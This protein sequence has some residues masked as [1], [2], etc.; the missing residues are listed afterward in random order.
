MLDKFIILIEHICYEN[1]VIFFLFIM[2]LF[3]DIRIFMFF[4]YKI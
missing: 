1:I 4:L 3:S 2:H